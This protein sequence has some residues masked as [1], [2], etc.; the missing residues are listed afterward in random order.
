VA[1]ARRNDEQG[2]RSSIVTSL[3]VHHVENN[4]DELER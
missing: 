1:R 4:V 2:I 3:R